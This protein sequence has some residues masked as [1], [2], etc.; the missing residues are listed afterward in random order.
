MKTQYKAVIVDEESKNL[1]SQILGIDAARFPTLVLDKPHWLVYDSLF[2][3]GYAALLP[4]AVYKERFTS[5][6]NRGDYHIVERI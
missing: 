6:E 2:S 1:C 3:T 4:H 5:V